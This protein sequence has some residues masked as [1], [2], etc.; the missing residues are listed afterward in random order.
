[1][2]MDSS[3]SVFFLPPVNE[4]LSLGDWGFHEGGAV[5]ESHVGQQVGGTHPTGM[6]SCLFVI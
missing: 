6:H 4:V 2:F 5:K 1:M 3:Y